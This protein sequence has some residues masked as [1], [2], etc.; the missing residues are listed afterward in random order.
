MLKILRVSNLTPKMGRRRPAWQLARSSS[1]DSLLWTKYACFRQFEPRIL[2]LTIRRGQSNFS[3][4]FIVVTCEEKGYYRIVSV[5]QVSFDCRSYCR[6]NRRMYGWR[7]KS[8]PV[9]YRTINQYGGTTYRPTFSRVNPVTMGC[10][11]TCEL[12]TLRVE[13]E[14]Y[15]CG[16]RQ[17]RI[18]K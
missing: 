11:W 7:R 13:G 2:K 4:V 14:I 18:Q 10:M 5:G 6:L 16:K 17:L 1:N 15:E 9:S 3:I 8:C 12:K